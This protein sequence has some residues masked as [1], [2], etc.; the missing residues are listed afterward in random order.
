[1]SKTFVRAA[2]AALVLVG[3]A[4]SASAQLAAPSP[5]KID[6]RPANAQSM[7]ETLKTLGGIAAAG[8]STFGSTVRRDAPLVMGGA[9]QT[10]QGGLLTLA[11]TVPSLAVAGTAGLQ[12]GGT[13]VEALGVGAG[14]ALD[15]SG[16]AVS[17]TKAK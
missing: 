2:V 9:A 6:T 4:S 13:A 17:T 11:A 10:V 16:N 1:M 7:S 15:V 3:F 8:T 5:V 12:V 14:W